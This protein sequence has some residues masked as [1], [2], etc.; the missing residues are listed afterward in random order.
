MSMSP[1][2]R[3]LGV[4]YSC[5][6]P[7][8]FNM[9]FLK[10]NCENL[11][12]TAIHLL[13]NSMFFSFICSLAVCHVS[14]RR[15]GGRCSGGSCSMPVYAMPT[16]VCFCAMSNISSHSCASGVRDKWFLLP[17]PHPI[18]SKKVRLP[19][20][21]ILHIFMWSLYVMFPLL[22]SCICKDTILGTFLSS[23]IVNISNQ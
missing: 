1:G 10:P 23:F 12:V 8:P 3:I 16:S 11:F 19:C 17:M 15:L 20:S 9:Q 6:K 2:V 14:N 21:S 7:C 4:G 22:Y 5:A 18:S 13:L